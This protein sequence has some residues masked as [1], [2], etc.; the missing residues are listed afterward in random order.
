[1]DRTQSVNGRQRKAR[2]RA[3]LCTYMTG[4]GIFREIVAAARS[5]VGR[6]MMLRMG[7]SHWTFR[8]RGSTRPRELLDDEVGR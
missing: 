7:R 2:S 6:L 8:P 1:M 3:H 4:S 5:C